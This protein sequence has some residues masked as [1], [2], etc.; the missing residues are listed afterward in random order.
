MHL[1]NSS[2]YGIRVWDILC[3]CL[4]VCLEHKVSGQ[5]A[6]TFAIARGEPVFVNVEVFGQKLQLCCDTGASI[7]TLDS[8]FRKQL[9]QALRK[10]TAATPTAQCRCRILLQPRICAFRCPH[11]SSTRQTSSSDVPISL[12]LNRYLE[13]NTRDF[14][15]WISSNHGF[16][17]LGSTIKLVNLRAFDLS[18]AGH[19]EK[20]YLRDGAPR[21]LMRLPSEGFVSFVVNTGDNV[22][23]TLT[24]KV[25]NR[26]VEKR[27][28]VPETPA[29][30]IGSDVV[31]C[32]SGVI[33]C[34]ELG[35]HRFFNVAVM[36]GTWQ[37][38][39]LG[40]LERFDVEF[41]FP[42]AIAV[43]RPGRHIDAP[44]RRLLGGL[45]VGKGE[46][47]VDHCEVR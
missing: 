23:L 4:A 21:L 35:P 25:F 29:P 26:L 7:T 47:G 28:L 12:R 32:R 2:K 14:L 17:G 13:S 20:L 18:N 42:N 19:V 24:R 9:G 45:A 16:Y 15:E 34:I 44:D 46:N 6:S 22:S 37:S 1:R 3:V 31:Q 41:D 5:E 11:L 10:E 43:F 36:E 30:S 40:F 39:G 27:K 38:V 8:S 33:E